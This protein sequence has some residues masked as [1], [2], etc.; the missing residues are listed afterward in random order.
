MLVNYKTV[1]E[2][3][4]GKVGIHRGSQEDTDCLV[5]TNKG[6]GLV[7]D[8]GSLEGYPRTSTEEETLAI[9][10]FTNKDS[11]WVLIEELLKLFVDKEEN[12]LL[13]TILLDKITRLEVISEVEREYVVREMTIRK[14]SVQDEG[15][16]LKLFINQKEEKNVK[17]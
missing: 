13:P 10:R 1:I 12:T 2:F 9:L 4:Q 7:G 16:T 15:Q 6:T 14:S 8:Y 11:L 3:G 5:L 17:S